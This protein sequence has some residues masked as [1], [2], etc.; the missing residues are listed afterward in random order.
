[1]AAKKKTGKKKGQGDRE[2]KAASAKPTSAEAPARAANAEATELAPAPKAKAKRDVLPLP[3]PLPQPVFPKET[4]PID[5]PL[6]MAAVLAIVLSVMIGLTWKR[7]S[8]AE[9]GGPLSAVPRESFL[10]ARIDVPTLRASPLYAAVIGEES[11]SKALGLEELARGCGFDPLARVDDLVV[12]IPE[13]EA[14][15]TFGLA[16]QVRLTESELATCADRLTAARGGKTTPKTVGAFHVLEEQKGERSTPGLAF[17]EGGLLVVA[18]GSWLASMLATAE[19]TRPRALE[20]DLHGELVR[21]LEADPSL[22]HPTIL[23]TAVLPT[24]LRERLK[25]ELS[26]ELAAAAGG[27]GGQSGDS[28]ESIMSAVLSVSAAG[29]GISARGGEELSARAELVC[30]TEAS[31]AV[32]GRLVERKRFGW[33]KDIAMRLIGLGSAVDSITAVPHGPSLTV[34]LHAP[35]DDLARGIARVLEYGRKKAP[36]PEPPTP[37]KRPPPDEVLSP[38][39]DAGAPSRPAGASGASGA[40]GEGAAGRPRPPSS[41]ELPPR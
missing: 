27:A 14:K 17:R 8:T 13:G 6:T 26:Q 22:S 33:S 41:E 19:G 12:A 5:N 23:A 29:L 32:L 4:S 3:A 11:A 39:R 21:T 20:K 16:A 25:N 40:S 1:M 37:S 34:K 2:A 28:P 30:E 38:K 31:A 10:V 9:S 24:S 7:V 35:T 15:G 18:E 36:A